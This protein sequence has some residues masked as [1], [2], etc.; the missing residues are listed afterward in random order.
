MHLVQDW[1]LN[2]RAKLNAAPGIARRT[3]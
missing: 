1:L 2:H 3:G